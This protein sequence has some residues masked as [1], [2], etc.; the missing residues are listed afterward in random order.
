[1]DREELLKLIAEDDLGLLKVKPKA[2]AAVNADERL[3]ASFHEI[4]QFVNENGAVRTDDGAWVLIEGF[5]LVFGR[6]KYVSAS[7]RDD[8][9]GMRRG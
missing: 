2:S 1:M 3:V 5:V 6:D 4:N 9:S 8:I 7:L